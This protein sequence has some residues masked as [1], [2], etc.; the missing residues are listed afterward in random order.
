[1]YTSAAAW[2]TLRSCWMPVGIRCPCAFRAA[3]VQR[4]STVPATTSQVSGHAARMEWATSI[5]SIPGM[6]LYLG[7]PPHCQ[8]DG[9]MRRNPELPLRLRAKFSGKGDI[10][11]GRVDRH[12]Q[13]GAPRDGAQPLGPLDFKRRAAAVEHEVDHRGP[14][15]EHMRGVVVEQHRADRRRRQTQ[16]GKRRCDWPRAAR[17]NPPWQMPGCAAI[18]RARAVGCPGRAGRSVRRSAA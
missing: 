6:A 4:S 11:L 16:R 9:G 7:I 5:K 13:C 1:M 2:Q 12:G 8:Q 17:H 3:D 18:E 15:P 10:R 14:G